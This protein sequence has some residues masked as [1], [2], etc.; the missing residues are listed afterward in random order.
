MLVLNLALALLNQNEWTTQ[1]SPITG[2]VDSLVR[3]VDKDGDELRDA[4]LASKVAE[5]LHKASRLSVNA[6][7]GTVQV[8]KECN[9]GVQFFSRDHFSIFNTCTGEVLIR[10]LFKE[11]KYRHSASAGTMPNNVS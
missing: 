5:E 8:Y 7:D 2:N 3:F 11:K 1:A 6:D 9:R 4:A 10:N